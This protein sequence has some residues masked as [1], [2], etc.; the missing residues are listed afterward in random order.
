MDST[1][2]HLMLNHVPI[3]GTVFGV[4]ILLA[5]VVF[6]SKGVTRAGLAAL[7]VSALFAIPVYLTGEPA[8]EVAE[9]LPGVTDAVI[10]VHESAAKF[11]FGLAIAT[12]VASVLAF[13]FTRAF[14]SKLS[15]T[16]AVGTLALAFVTGG[17]MLQTANLGG[18]IRHTEIRAAT[19]DPGIAE[20]DGKEVRKKGDDDDD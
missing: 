9:A 8:E 17:S 7:L 1:H 16:M 2:L 19:Q 18:Q 12:G 5:G 15:M 4:L 11:A 13:A 20:K 10:E 14:P 6:R 3:L